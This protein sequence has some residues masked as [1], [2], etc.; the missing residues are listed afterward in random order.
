MLTA[1]TAYA[2][3]CMAALIK[4]GV[5]VVSPRTVLFQCAQNW[6]RRTFQQVLE[7]G[8]VSVPDLSQVLSDLCFLYRKGEESEF[9]FLYML[10]NYDRTLDDVAETNT[11]LISTLIGMGAHA[12]GGWHFRRQML[13]SPL[14]GYITNMAREVFELL[15]EHGA[16][17]NWVDDHGLTPMMELMNGLCMVS[18]TRAVA[19]PSPQKTRTRNGPAG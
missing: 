5:A 18:W 12:E 17:V 4:N 10:V 19:S 8:E 13:S 9:S 2:D 11:H 1:G 14:H 6:R 15:V 7:R 3:D 16:D